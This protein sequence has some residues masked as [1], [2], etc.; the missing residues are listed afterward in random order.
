MAVSLPVAELFLFERSILREACAAMGIPVGLSPR[1]LSGRALIAHLYK[2]AMG[3]RQP[4]GTG[5]TLLCLPDD[6]RA[7]GAFSLPQPPSLAALAPC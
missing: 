1:V 5:G 3:D 6:E 7:L 4:C 2:C